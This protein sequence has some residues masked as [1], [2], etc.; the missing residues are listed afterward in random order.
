M[1]VC[2]VSQG[3]GPE[4]VHVMLT[5]RKARRC[6]AHAVEGPFGSGSDAPWDNLRNQT[7]TGVCLDKAI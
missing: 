5:K 2:F 4:M 7:V 6:V 3:F 1:F